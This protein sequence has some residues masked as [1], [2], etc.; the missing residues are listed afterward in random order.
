MLYYKNT[1]TL[2]C[3]GA[4]EGQVSWYSSQGLRVLVVARRILPEASWKEL[5]SAIEVA[6]NGTAPSIIKQA[7]SAVETSLTLIGS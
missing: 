7:Y 4:T 1:K 3:L 6:E 5:K 2:N